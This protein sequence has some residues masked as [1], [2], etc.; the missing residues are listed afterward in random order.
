MAYG[1]PSREGAAPLPGPAQGAGDSWI[2]LWGLNLGPGMVRG[3][4]NAKRP[5]KLPLKFCVGRDYSAI[6]MTEKN[7]RPSDDVIFAGNRAW[8]NGFGECVAVDLDSGRAIQRAAHVTDDPAQGVSWAADGTWVFGNRLNRAA[9]L[10][11]SRVYCV[12]DNYRSGIGPNMRERMER[13]GGREVL[14]PLPCGN[15]LAAY[16]A[17][18]GRLLWRIGRELP[19]ETPV[20]APGRW[21]VNA[22]RFAA[23]P[24]PCAGLLL[25]PVEDDSG[26][27]V[28]GLDADSGA[29]VWRTRLT[30]KFPSA[31]PRAAPVNVTVDG[32]YA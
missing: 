23:P 19:A 8:V 2:L 13:I 31:A 20:Q 28:V 4:L 27:G 14:R 30:S 10:I 25:A 7:Y 18:T 29:Q 15:A 26:L 12:E 24:V 5:A 1:G 3:G 17:D 22:I 32:A 16:E 21:R 9:A 11:G 6:S